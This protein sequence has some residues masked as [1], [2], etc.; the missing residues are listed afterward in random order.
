IAALLLFH[1]ASSM[2]TFPDYLAYSNELIGGTSRT[3]LR[4]SDSNVDWGQGLRETRQYLAQHNIKDCWLAYFG[5]ADPAY[6]DLPCKLLPD[7][8]LRWWGDPIEVP[9]E[10]YHGTVLISGTEV[11]APYWGPD[12]LNPYATFLNRRPVANIGGS[13][14]VFDGDV[15]L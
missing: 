4:L 7:P 8:F 14:L 3:Y 11:A 15:D 2:H 1:L 10:S 9:P 6:Y 12:A 13:I 5:S